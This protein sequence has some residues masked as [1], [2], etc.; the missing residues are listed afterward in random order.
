MTQVFKTR[1]MIWG[2]YLP[3]A[4]FLFPLF[5]LVLGVLLASEMI[6]KSYRGTM[7]QAEL[8]DELRSTQ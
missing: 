7:R 3:L 6:S 2:F 1:L 8:E 5:S 4:I